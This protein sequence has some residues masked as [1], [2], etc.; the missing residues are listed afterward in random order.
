MPNN[1]SFYDKINWLFRKYGEN[2]HTKSVILIGIFFDGDFFELTFG[3]QMTVEL[4]DLIWRH[5]LS[6]LF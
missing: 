2:I 4:F 5:L 3:N 6:E 1:K